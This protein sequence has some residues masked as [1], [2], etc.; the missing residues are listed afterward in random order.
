LIEFRGIGSAYRHDQWREQDLQ[1]RSNTN[2]SNDQHCDERWQRDGSRRRAERH[3]ASV[4]QTELADVF[5]LDDDVALGVAIARDKRLRSHAVDRSSWLDGCADGSNTSARELLQQWREYG[6]TIGKVQLLVGRVDWHVGRRAQRS[7]A[8]EGGQGACHLDVVE[9]VGRREA[10]HQSHHRV[11]ARHGVLV[12]WHALG[13][14]ALA[15]GLELSPQHLGHAA[16]R[17]GQVGRP[18]RVHKEALVVL[19]G[20]AAVVCPGLEVHD[21]VADVQHAGQSL[22]VGSRCVSNDG[23][24]LVVADRQSNG[25]CLCVAD[26]GQ[27]VANVAV[28]LNIEQRREIWVGGQPLLGT[29]RKVHALQH[30][31]A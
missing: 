11:E 25:L 28:V 21:E 14:D 2:N 13:R 29:S 20:A 4:G 16:G 31:N 15:L 5:V 22:L 7:V 10:R 3:I 19:R 8:L 23:L 1:A 18:L 24:D 12:E 26:A 27:Q 9:R 6:L 17:E 30:T